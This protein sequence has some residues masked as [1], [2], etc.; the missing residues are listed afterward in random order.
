MA[1][2]KKI[3][4]VDDDADLRHTLAD[5]LDLREE[6]DTAE[7]DCGAAA[8]DQVTREHFDLVLLDIGLPDMDG[9]EVCRLLRRKGIQ[10]PVIM[11]TAKDSD[12]DAILGLDSELLVTLIER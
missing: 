2:Q 12:A 11:L 8:I 4:I 1:P 6:F 5:Q 3:L 7:A 10:V 9:R